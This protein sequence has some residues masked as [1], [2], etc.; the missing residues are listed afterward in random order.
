[1]HRVRGKT[2]WQ[3]YKHYEIPGLLSSARN[4]R[5]NADKTLQKNRPHRR[6]IIYYLPSHLLFQAAVYY[7]LSYHLKVLLVTA[8]L[9]C[10]I[11]HLPQLVFKFGLKD[12][13]DK[14]HPV[15]KISVHP[16]RRAN[17]ELSVVNVF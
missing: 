10:N 8:L 13:S 17:V 12:R 11:K 15:V 7:L 9:S 14:L 4:G 3:S 16:V 2:T 6:S 1:M 5:Y